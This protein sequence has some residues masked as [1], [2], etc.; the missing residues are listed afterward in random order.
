MRWPAKIHRSKGYTKREVCSPESTSVEPAKISA[1]QITGGNHLRK[2]ITARIIVAGRKTCKP[3]LRRSASTS[4]CNPHASPDLSQQSLAIIMGGG[5]GTRLYPLTK[6]RAKPAVPLGG[7]YRLVDIP[8]SNCLNSGMRKIYVLTQFNT[9]S[10]HQHIAASYK[11]DNLSTTRSFVEILA[12]QQT[13][14][15]VEWYQGTA[16]AVRQNLRYFLEHPAQYF[17]ILSGDQLYHMDYPRPAPAARRNRR[18]HHAGNR[19]GGAEGSQR[20]RHHAQPPGPAHLPV[21]GKTERPQDARR[22]ENPCA[23]ARRTRPSAPTR[24][25]FRRAWAFTCSTGRCSSTRLNND[26]ADFGKHIIPS[27]IEKHRVHAY[28]FQG[29][30]EDIGTIRAFFEANLRPDRHHPAVRFLRP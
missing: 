12:A 4:P 15:S 21:P 17:V 1:I 19:A 18:G 8:I 16:D 3:S 13:Q 7:K 9:T 14:E 23:V 5:A 25:C 30:W 11:F 27:A 29:Y 20:I 26:F 22:P 6:E 2:T 28:I 24:S 10:L